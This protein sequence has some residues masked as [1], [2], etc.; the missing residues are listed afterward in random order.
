MAGSVNEFIKNVYCEKDIYFLT[1]HII[2]THYFSLHMILTF[3]HCNLSF[4]MTSLL[5]LR[6][7][8]ELG[9]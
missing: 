5:K 2:I 9:K 8:T 3:K 7:H 4:K 1:S 6:S